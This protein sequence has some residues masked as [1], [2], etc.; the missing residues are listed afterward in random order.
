VKLFDR[1]PSLTPR[2]LRLATLGV[3]VLLVAVSGYGV[4]HRLYHNRIALTR[5]WVPLDGMPILGAHQSRAKVTIVAFLD[6]RSPRSVGMAR[7]LDKI[8]VDQSDRARM[9][10]RLVVD[11]NDGQSVLAGRSALAAAGQYKFWEFHRWLID[12]AAPPSA[13]AIEAWAA[14]EKLDL[15]Q[16]RLERDSQAAGLLLESQWES[17]RTIC[18]KG[19]PTVFVNGRAVEGPAPMRVLKSVVRQEYAAADALL[20]RGT[21]PTAVYASLVAAKAR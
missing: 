2:H 7:T 16:F 13:D 6:Y 4:Y 10:I 12:Q 14:R 9:Q 15:P 18:I 21:S 11:P 8:L 3:A 20:S 19:V 1:K 5:T 17:A